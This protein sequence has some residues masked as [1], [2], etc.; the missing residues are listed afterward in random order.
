MACVFGEAVV[1][2]LAPE[3]TLDVGEAGW[4]GAG[5]GGVDRGVTLEVD[6]EGS[7]AVG[8]VAELLTLD[9]GVGLEVLVAQVLGT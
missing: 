5:C 3:S 8:G 4:I 7:A 2:L 6:V 9:G 1:D